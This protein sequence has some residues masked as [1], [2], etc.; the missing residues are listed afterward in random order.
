M[1]TGY[2]GLPKFWTSSA[3]LHRIAGWSIDLSRTVFFEKVLPDPAESEDVTVA[4]T[5]M[6]NDLASGLDRAI[7]ISCKAYEERIRW[8]WSRN[9]D[10]DRANGVEM[11]EVF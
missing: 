7:T 5:E 9:N 4:L 10:K 3:D 2:Q 6:A 8:Y 1:T 11:K